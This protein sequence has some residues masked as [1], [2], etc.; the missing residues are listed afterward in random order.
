MG[1]TIARLRALSPLGPIFGKELRSTARR[2]RTYVLRFLYLAILLTIMLFFFT[3]ATLNLRGQSNSAVRQSQ[4]LAE[5]GAIFFAVFSF[6]TLSSMALLGPVLTATAIN[7]ERLHKTLAVLLMTPIT[8]WQIVAGK[9]FS[10]LLIA[11]TLIGLTLPALSVVRLLGGIETGQIVGALALSISVVIAA[12]ALGLLLST[13]MNRAYSVILLS[14]GTML[15][16][17]ALTPMVIAMVMA[18]LTRT[19]SGRGPPGYWF[20]MHFVNLTNPFFVMGT[21]VATRG[22]MP[23]KLLSWEYCAAVHFAA[24]AALL[25]LC[26]FFLRRIAKKETDAHPHAPV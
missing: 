5:M 21:L 17:Y 22:G 9:L 18:T 1:I 11:L 10:R 8:A 23:F 24:A 20:L 26:G 19:S 7:S 4:Q 14:Y 13:L 12:A 16:V 15:I 6:F 3:V 25:L 2:R